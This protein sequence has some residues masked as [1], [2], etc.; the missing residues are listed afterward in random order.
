[1]VYNFIT[2]EKLLTKTGIGK[3][4]NNKQTANHSQA[5]EM[6]DENL[7]HGGVSLLRSH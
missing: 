3:Q 7:I 1:V 2:G 6:G 5:R 4:R